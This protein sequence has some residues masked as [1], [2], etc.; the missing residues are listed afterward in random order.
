MNEFT[1][2]KHFI[3]I[4]ISKDHLDFA[5]I[6]MSVP[7]VYRD[8]QVANSYAGFGKIKNWLAREKVKLSDCLFCMEHT[9]TYGLLLI[10]WL[11]RMGLGFTVEPAIQ[12][13]RSIGLTRGK[14]DVVD[15]RRIADYAYTNRSKLDRF[16]LPSKLLL[17]IKQRLT[18][19]DQQTKIKVSLKNSLKS[20]NQ[21]NE[22]LGSTGISHEIQ[23]QIDECEHRIG[24]IDRQIKELIRS[25]D[26]LKN[27][28]ELSLSVK[29]IGPVIAAFMLVTT[30]NYTSFDNGRKYACYCGIAPFDNASGKYQGKPKVSHLANKRIKALLSNAAN[31]AYRWDPEIKGYYQRKIEEGKH[32][33]SVINAVKCKLVNRVFAV[34][35]RQTPY[36]NIYKETFA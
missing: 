32:H 25:D 35:K 36:V 9:G 13:Q 7:D 8:K 5:L 29:G 31:S 14:N 17:Q 33:N 28:Y 3:G 10:A 24:N 15:A 21:Y 1:K 26:K 18:Y 2:K 6:D 23:N 11:S 16:Q 27:N 34:V 20:H 12:I 19:R 22:I 30:I 4:D